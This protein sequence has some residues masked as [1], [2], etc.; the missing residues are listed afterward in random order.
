M[1]MNAE[2][3][4]Q[5]EEPQINVAD[6]LGTKEKTKELRKSIIRELLKYPE[7]IAIPDLAQNLNENRPKLDTNHLPLFEKVGIVENVITTSK[8]GR[9]VV[10]IKLKDDINILPLLSMFGDIFQTEYGE[11]FMEVHK[12]E[13][14]DL[15][16]ENLKSINYD[17]FFD[18]N[19]TG[20]L[21]KKIGGYYMASLLDIEQIE[22]WNKIARIEG[23][24]KEMTREE[25]LKRIIPQDE[26]EIDYLI[27]LKEKL[28][29]FIKFN[30]ESI[31]N[32]LDIINEIEG[33]DS[34]V[35]KDIYFKT[36]MKPVNDQTDKLFS[37]ILDAYKQM[38]GDRDDT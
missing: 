38:R 23:L 16:S 8:K 17:R 27:S 36:V 22:D 3:E 10:G 31:I 34:E 11:K 26:S 25:F 28:L 18:E 15:F 32:D 5:T 13:V 33:H 29:R 6:L 14:H 7:G 35:V 1:Y 4:T 21:V 9:K 24:L 30:V 12:E 2:I 19:D 20:F 37:D